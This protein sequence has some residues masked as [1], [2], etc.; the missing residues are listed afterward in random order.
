MGCEFN[1][2]KLK[3]KTVEEAKR[4]VN[5]IIE[6]A[7]YDHGHSG[8]TGSFAEATGVVY[9]NSVV[10]DD[11][12]DAEEYLVDFADKWGPAIIVKVADGAFYV[13]ANCSS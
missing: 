12:E 8:Y 6:Q 4:E 13:G 2:C 10:H 11:P 3:A 9:D 7:A 5:A 1:F